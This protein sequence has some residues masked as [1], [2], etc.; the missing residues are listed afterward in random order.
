[1]VDGKRETPGIYTRPEC[2]VGLGIHIHKE[3]FFL[4][5]FSQPGTE[6]N[7]RGSLARPSFL[8][9]DG[10]NPCHISTIYRFSS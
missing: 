10:Y 3:G 9:G 7:C 5:E 1:M 4:V 2:A 8:I 6:V